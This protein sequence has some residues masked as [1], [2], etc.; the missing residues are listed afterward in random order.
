MCKCLLCLVCPQQ[1]RGL[2]WLSP[3]CCMFSFSL[4]TKNSFYTS[5]SLK[6]NAKKSNSQHMK[7]IWNPNFSVPKSSLT[8]TQPRPLLHAL[9]M[10]LPTLATGGG[11]VVSSWWSPCGFPLLQAHC[12]APQ[13]YTCNLIVSIQLGGHFFSLLFSKYQDNTIHCATCLTQAGNIF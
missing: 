13:E 8:C 9:F 4:W 3:A 5:E 12:W 1:S 7:I 2:F 10:L 6:R 11:C